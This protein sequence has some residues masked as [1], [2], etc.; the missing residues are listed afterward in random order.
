MALGEAFL[1]KPSTNFY[2]ENALTL[3]ARSVATK[4]T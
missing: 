2:L 1:S 3:V 4:V